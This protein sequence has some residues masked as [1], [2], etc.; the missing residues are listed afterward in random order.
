M[1]HKSPHKHN[2]LHIAIHPNTAR[3]LQQFAK[4]MGKNDK[5]TKARAANEALVMA[6]LLTGDLEVGEAFVP[7]QGLGFVPYHDTPELFAEVG[8]DVPSSEDL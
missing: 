2:Y 7:I 8:I 1:A 3:A 4:R 5:L 6:M